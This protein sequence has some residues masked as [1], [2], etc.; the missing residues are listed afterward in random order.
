MWLGQA[1]PPELPA[2]AQALP[3]TTQN[4]G[5]G[6]RLTWNEKEAPSQSSVI[7]PAMEE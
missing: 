2:S 3:G 1:R 7:S 5:V 4:T 6:T